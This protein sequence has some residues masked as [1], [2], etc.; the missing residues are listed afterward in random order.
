MAD[1]SQYSSDTYSNKRKYEE[2][3][4]PPPSTR[5]PTGFSSGPIPSA[6]PDPTATAVPPPSSY[7]SV[8]PPLDE[9][10]IAK[11]KAQEIAAR[12]LNS[13][14]AK[15]PRVENGASYD[16]ADK[17][18]SS[19]PSS[20]GK[21]M[22]G[23]V[24]SSIPVSYGSFQGTTKK[25]DIPNMRVGVII[26]KGG[27]TIKYLQLQSG[28]K[29]Q[30]TRDMD[31]DP[32]CP[33]RTVDLTGTPDQISKAEQLITDVLQEAEAGGSAGSGGGGRRMGGQAGADQFVMKIPNNKVGLI[34]GKGGETIKSM[35]AK[36]GARIQVIP[37]HLPPG[38]PTPERT[39]QIDGITD[40]I[41][42]AKQLVNEIISGENR[43]R[44]SSMGGGY[45]QQGGYQAR[46]PSSWAP[47]GGPP[48]QPG[49]GGY[50]QPGAYPGP[51]QYGQ[52]PY[53]SY[54]QQTSA[55][56]SST[57]DQSSVPPSQQGAQGEYD[58]YGQQQSQQP[59]TGGSS[60][61]PTDATGYNYYQHASGYGQAGQGYQ[62]DGYGAYN[63][64]Q[65]SGYGQ[66]AGY[67]QQQAGYGSAA[68]P[69]QEE[70]T[71]QAAPPSSAQS[72]QAGYGTTG[73]QP[74]QGSTGQ[75]GYGAAPTS[76]AGYSS[77]PPAAYSSG[78][79]AP[80]PAAKP[81]AY[82][83]SQQSPGAPG[84]YGSQSGYA[85][86]AA[87]GYGQPPAYG[88][89]QAPQAYGSYG[90]YPQAAA[91]GSYS[92]DGSAGAAAAGGGGGTPASQTAAPPAGP[93]KASPKS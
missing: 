25:I 26:G 44:N 21:Q 68:N 66:A 61:A 18:F 30:V 57:W 34:I 71:S 63:A 78:Y 35:Q 36:T 40:Q 33:T 32:N 65:Q 88:Y 74:P 70:D 92:S 22:S 14:D 17:G 56:Y 67:D 86:P 23:T 72:G 13:A 31:A 11:Q 90:G 79:G 2:P 38:D 12:L 42:H 58:Y 1:E 7:N 20:E 5:R 3:T 89:G 48:A 37:L 82:G 51:P 41:E 83:Q 81:P 6:S 59:S 19:Y 27:E 15:R 28:A 93:P 60:A 75:A 84:S 69:S 10:Q 16:Y 24:P 52:S 62:Q 46:P 47:P 49:Y 55:G 50:M 9:I 64:S 43:M 76:Q 87:S 80:P 77:Q 39:L 29:I 45:P 53:G 85:Q 91:G 4:A 73:Q 8:P 54:P